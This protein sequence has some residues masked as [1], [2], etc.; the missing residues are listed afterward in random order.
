MQSHGQ[1]LACPNDRQ[2]VAGGMRLCPHSLSP[3]KRANCYEVEHSKSEQWSGRR[4]WNGRQ[5]AS[6]SPQ[7]PGLSRKR[8]CFHAMPVGWKSTNAKAL[9]SSGP[10]FVSR[11]AAAGPQEG[12][13]CNEKGFLS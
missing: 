7:L 2:A 11:L 10:A 13:D 3:L 12:C 4:P 5:N 9:T 1:N 6:H 8:P